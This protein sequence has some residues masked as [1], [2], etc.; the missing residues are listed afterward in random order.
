VPWQ[1]L[2]RKGRDFVAYGPSADEIA[3]FT[4][5]PAREPIRVYVGSASAPT[6]QGRAELAVR[7][8]YRTGAFDRSVLVLAMPTG[9]GMVEPF[10]ADSL[11]YLHAGDTAIVAVQYSARPSWLSVVMDRRAAQTTAMAV[12]D[13]V[14]AAW[15]ARPAAQRPALYLYGHSLGAEA[16]G[17]VVDRLESAAERGAG[18]AGASGGPMALGDPINGALL[19]GPP[20][21]WRSAAYPAWVR[22]MR[23]PSDPVALFSPALAVLKPGW[24]GP[25]RPA[26]LDPAMRW[27]PFVTFL[28]VAAD[29]PQAVFV[30]WGN[31]HMYSEVDYGSAWAA[32]SGLG[33]LTPSQQQRLLEQMRQDSSPVVGLLD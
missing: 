3:A 16:F 17:P 30:P 31:G 1:S 8:L 20:V 21:A 27:V 33:E 29:L 32:L 26:G 23:H 28:Q 12:F 25:Q 7:E 6:L 15:Q 10:A 11:E 19:A 5:S 22:V 2:G 13:E 14:Y 9:T 4:G 24:R 18:T